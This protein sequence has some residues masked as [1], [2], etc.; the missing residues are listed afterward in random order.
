MEKGGLATALAAA[1]LTGS[2]CVGCCDEMRVGLHGTVRRV[3]GRRGVTVRQRV[4]FA[5]QWRYLVLVVD[6]RRGRIWWNWNETMQA[7]E[8]I[9]LMRGMQDTTDLEAVVWDGAPSH[10]DERLAR[11]GL[12]LIALPPSAP[13]LNP[14]ERLFEEIRGEI[15]GEVY[16]T[17]ADKVAAVDALLRDLDADPAR[18]QRLAGWTWIHA[19]FAALPAAI[20][21]D[22]IAA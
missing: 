3:W 8:L 14:A 12:P 7:H 18:V 22:P 19:A 21:P 17:L 9:P 5:Y 15:E 11:I 10:R 6:G 2:S 1:G 4:Q 20:E 16:A 13:E